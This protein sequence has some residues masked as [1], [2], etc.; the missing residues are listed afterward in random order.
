[1]LLSLIVLRYGNRR[2]VSW[3][4]FILALVTFHS[5]AQSLN[6]PW[7]GNAHDPQSS[8]VSTVPG[9]TLSQIHWQTPVDLAP[10]FSGNDLLIHYGC[11]VITASNTVIVPVKTNSSGGFRIEG[12]RGSDGLL[13]Y[14]LNSDYSLPPH[15][16]TPSYSPTLTP[17]NR[18]YF[19]GGGGTVYYRDNPD[20]PGGGVTGQLAFY[21]LTNF[22]SNANTYLTNVKISTPLTSDR[23]GNVYFGFYVAGSTPLNL[24]SGIARISFDGTGSWV[25][26]TNLVGDTNVVEVSHNCAAKFS[27]DSKNFYI[28]IAGSGSSYGYL[29]CVDSQSL[30]LV[31]K[32]QLKD[33]YPLSAPNSSLS[34]SSSACPTIGPDG[35]VYFGVLE[36]N[37]GFNHYRGWLLHFDATLTQTKIPG[38]FGWDDTAS[39][40][41]AS[42]VPSYH[43][44]SSYLLCTKY[45]NYAGG[46][47]DG[48]NK[49]AILDPFASE[50]DPITGATVMK[51]VLTVAGVTPDSEYR[52]PAHPDA[53]RE[54]CINTA[55]VDPFAKA[56]FVNSE[57]GRLYRWN[58]IHN[59]LD[60]VVTL[61][62]GVGEAYT[63]TVIGMD[64]TVY[65]VNNATLYAVGQ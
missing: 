23:Y 30:A 33:P 63:P 31:S 3:L 17:K 5:R 34:E 56:V 1:M 2:L 55:V 8:A 47:G 59:A 38:A 60:Q 27:N 52:S 35:D 39:I 4:G 61:T 44:S 7:R 21:G 42:V 53:V 14:A 57:D 6:I 45:N 11:P 58:L 22:Q 18:V 48:V 26:A 10:A 15:N 13:L 20:S 24:R 12:H 36:H 65:A 37:Q 40:V 50:V 51:E 25:S 29:A 46:G 16:W 28:A 49:V 9:Q 54:W 43:G 64:G 32:I 19:A 62:P 41:P